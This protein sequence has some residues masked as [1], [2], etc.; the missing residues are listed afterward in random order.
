[1]AEVGQR[2]RHT[3][4]SPKVNF[5][6][7]STKTHRVK[8]ICEESYEYTLVKQSFVTRGVGLQYDQCFRMQMRCSRG[9]HTTCGILAQ[10]MSG[11]GQSP[12]RLHMRL[13]E[14]SLFLVKYRY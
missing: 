8:C 6:V 1:M 4:R 5:C 2:V 3:T 7:E 11:L 10:H 13:I 9:Y 12:M 14:I